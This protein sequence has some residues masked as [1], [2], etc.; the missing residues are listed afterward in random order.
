[1]PI[2]HFSPSPSSSARIASQR[3]SAAAPFVPRRS[4]R[5]SPG[6]SASP[7]G[8]AAYAASYSA[9]AAISSA[10]SERWRAASAGQRA[11]AGDRGTPISTP[12]RAAASVISRTAAFVACAA[13]NATGSPGPRPSADGARK[14]ACKAK[15]GMLKTAY[16]PCLSS[17]RALALDQIRKRFPLAPPL[18]RHPEIQR[19]ADRARRVLDPIERERAL[20]LDPRLR[21]GR[22]RTGGEHARE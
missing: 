12:S 11:S 19:G 16:M 20:Q 3:S 9:A 13:I 8:E 14:T 2:Q 5:L 7:R 17:A 15:L 22:D 1:I 21:A 10:R 18:A 4:T 6:P